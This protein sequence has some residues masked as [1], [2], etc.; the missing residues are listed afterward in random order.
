MFIA[1]TIAQMREV[2][3]NA[4]HVFGCRR[5]GFVPTMGALHAGHFSLI[6]AARRD[7]DFVVVSIFVNPMQF[8]PSEDLSRYPRPLEADLAGCREHK[9]DAVF[10]PD[11]AEMYPPGSLTTIHV[12]KLTVYLCGANRP[13]HF[14][15]VATVV[16]K[17]FN[18][19]QPDV[20]YFGSKDYQQ[21]AMIRRM[22]D[23]LSIP[24]R[25]EV[26]PT[27]REPDGLA[28]SSRNAYLAP[29]Q[30]R[31]AVA[32]VESLQRARDMMADGESRSAEVIGMM[33]RYIAERAPLGQ[34]DYIEIVKP[35]TLESV[36]EIVG[37]VV[38]A[39]AVKFPSARLIDNML[40][41]R[42]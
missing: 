23:D 16:T 36:R 15:G 1:K 19:V 11:A 10:L 4:R 20:S 13:G 28:M 3:A 25:V 24:V 12:A 22:V 41:S 40:C 31:Q 32:L 42:S 17:L 34:V 8:G 27:V 2:V 39:L 33:R 21:V 5:V 14:D 30:R 18:I 6:D 37:P 38:V 29:A 9:A 26:C 35:D 7:C